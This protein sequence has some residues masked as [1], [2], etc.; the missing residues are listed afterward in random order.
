MR[1]N[2]FK[3]FAASAAVC[4]VSGLVL[5]NNG[6]DK[7]KAVEPEVICNYT[8]D[9]GN[10]EGIIQKGSTTYTI[11]EGL[12]S[13]YNGSTGTA[14]LKVVRG[15]ESDWWERSGVKFDLKKLKPGVTYKVSVDVYHESNAIMN[16]EEEKY[17]D[18]RAFKIGTYYTTPGSGDDATAQYG[19]IG[20]VMGPEKNQW[21]RI[22]GTITIKEDVK[23]EGAGDYFMH[24]FMGYPEA[25]GSGSTVGGY[26]DDGVVNE[27]Y[28]IDNFSIIEV[29]PATPTPVPTATPVPTPAPTA[30]PTLP[31][32]AEGPELEVGYEEAVKGIMYKVSGLDTVTVIGFDMPKSKLVIPDTIMLEGY[33]YKVTAIANNAFKGEN[34]KNLTIGANVTTIGKNAFANC[35]SLKKV[36]IKSTVI[37]SIGKKAFAK[38]PKKATFKVPKAKKAAYKKLLKKAGIN[39]KA[40]VK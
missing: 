22:G 25:L 10:Y 11:E 16:G 19:Q 37:K 30:E 9:D 29:L 8:F 21:E 6:A 15:N 4:F 35:K 20:S 7:A 2:L 32:V 3:V 36:T 34:I 13:N 27:P 28:W 5:F 18:I 1:K 38:T 14:C 40:K 33:A 39:K 24:I 23:A 12:N 17:P 26:T 31:P